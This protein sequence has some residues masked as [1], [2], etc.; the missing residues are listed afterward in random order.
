MPSSLSKDSLYIFYLFASLQ[1]GASGIG[2]SEVSYVIP[3]GS[4]AIEAQGGEQSPA[5]CLVSL[6]HGPSVA[7]TR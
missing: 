1:N 4:G 2:R 6:G 5:R 7:L 3:P